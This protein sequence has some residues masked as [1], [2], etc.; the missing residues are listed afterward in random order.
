[1]PEA[2]LMDK[3]KIVKRAKVV[4]GIEAEAINILKR[5]IGKDF[6]KALDL[7]SGCKGRVIVTGMGKS[8]VVARKIAATLSSTGT[9]AL[10]LH[11][12][13]GSHGDLGMILSQD[14]V[15]AISNSGGTQ[16]IVQLLPAI[17]RI[18][19]KFIIFTSNTRSVLAKNS[20]IVLN[21]KVKKE[22]C[23][24]GL[25]PTASTTAAMALGDA[26]AICLLELMEFKEEDYALFHPGGSLGKKLLLKIADIM[27]K[28][29]N[30][31]K[32][33]TDVSIKDLILEMSSKRLGMT[34]VVNDKGEL[35]GVISDGDL[36]RLM[37]K[38][39]NKLF[40]AKAGDFMTKNPRILDKNELAVKALRC[41]EQNEISFVI[42]VDKQ[43]KPE[44][45]LHIHD[46][47][48]AG[49]A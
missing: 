11:P 46:I 17:R 38:L 43:N 25:A 4:L 23:P 40:K 32:V 15:L 28:G 19:A 27:H 47:L 41:M 48:I 7:I 1:M 9:P 22:A 36:R 29:D 12:A 6:I 34:T 10:F 24:M 44:G 31:A 18:G 16:E 30:I 2:I 42:C 14:I 3:D 5:N 13:E 8:G 39:G 35:A 33:K 20:D 49:V 37:E 26:L 21:L 45:I